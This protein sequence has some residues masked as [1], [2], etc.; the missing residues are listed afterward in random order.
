ML[1]SWL[2]QTLTI[3]AMN[4]RTIP[5]RRGPAL[6]AILGIAGVVTVLLT[7]MSIGQGFEQTLSGTGSPESVIVLQAGDGSELT[8]NLQLDEARIIADAPGLRRGA[9]GVAASAEYFEL[10][11][12]PKRST[13][14]DAMLPLRGV[15]PAAP[16]V[17]DDFRIVAGRMFEPGRHEVV[18]GQS[19]AAGF[20]GLD[21]GSVQRFGQAEWTV[22]GIFSTGGT[23]VDSELWCDVRVLGS[24]YRRTGFQSVHARLESAEAFDGFRDAL[25]RDLRTQVR[26]MRESDFYAGY[27]GTVTSSV[28]AVAATI[29]LLMGICATFGTLNTMYSAVSARTREIATLRAIGFGAAPAAISVLSESLALAVVGGLLGGALAYLGFHGYQA[30]TMNWSTYSQLAFAFQVTPALLIQGVAYALAIGLVGGL[31]PAQRAARL[32]IA[33]ALREA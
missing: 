11:E 14:T 13:G 16:A 28:N 20:E 32:P 6:V 24:V 26:V 7:V 9:E 23:L 22:V 12:L 4:A 27:A 10:V 5:E 25:T 30:T 3:S 31:L 19:A 29:A 1:R 33:T 8:S 2:T 18:A 17:R 15:E 21:I